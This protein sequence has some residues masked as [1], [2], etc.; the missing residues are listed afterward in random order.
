MNSIRYYCRIGEL[1]FDSKM[2]PNPGLNQIAVVARGVVE[3]A[4]LSLY[5]TAPDGL[6]TFADEAIGAVTEVGSRAGAHD[7]GIEKSDLVSIELTSG[8]VSE[9]VFTGEVISTDNNL[10]L[11]TVEVASDAYKLST[12]RV[13]Q[14]FENQSA[15]QIISELVDDVGITIGNV[16]ASSSYPYF[17]VN[18]NRSI[19]DHIR[20]LAS[21]EGMECYFNVNNELVVEKFSRTSADHELIY[22]KHILDLE[23]F[24]SKPVTSHTRVYT[25]SPASTQ[26]QDTWHW[27]TKDSS[28]FT[29]SA[30]TGSNLFSITDGSVRTKDSADQFAVHKL[31]AIK[32]IS[33]TGRLKLLGNPTIKIA[34]AIETRNIPKP[35]LNGLFKVT[36]VEHRFNKTEGYITLVNFTGH[37]GASEIAGLPAD[38]NELTSAIGF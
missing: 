34:D 27:L 33:T 35:E 11:T 38:V 15:D 10:G 7:Y 6:T 19:S 32:D 24:A 13:N 25:E 36:G 18:E 30:G 5:F 14:I 23:I 2:D 4:T 22:G 26:G 28:S 21:R 12:A 8:E 17:V 20:L 9:V 37:G 29:S 3:H 31:G 1:T 16:S